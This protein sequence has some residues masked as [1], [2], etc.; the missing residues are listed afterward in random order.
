MKTEYSI[1]IINEN[2]IRETKEPISISENKVKISGWAIDQPAQKSASDVIVV[3][4]GKDYKSTFGTER[5]D[6][7]D[8]YNNS[9]YNNSGWRIEIPT[10]LIGKGEHKLKLKILAFD[11]LSYYETEKEIVILVQ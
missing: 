11:K 8:F 6:V 1:D 3:I 10:A 9:A 2:L 7:A 5:P 4:D